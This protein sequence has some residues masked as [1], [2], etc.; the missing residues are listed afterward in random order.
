VIQVTGLIES[1]QA[2]CG[3]TQAASDSSICVLPGKSSLGYCR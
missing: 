2:S 1:M 3:A